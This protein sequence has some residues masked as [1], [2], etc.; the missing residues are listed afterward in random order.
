MAQDSKDEVPSTTKKRRRRL[1]ILASAGP[2]RQTRAVTRAANNVKV[3]KRRSARQA[4]NNIKL[5][6]GLESEDDSSH[7]LD[8]EEEVVDGATASDVFQ[9]HRQVRQ[10]M[11][12][13]S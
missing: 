4:K 3:G 6:E 8:D 11:L 5:E 1:P 12:T 9:D 13:I 7:R 10:G 2:R